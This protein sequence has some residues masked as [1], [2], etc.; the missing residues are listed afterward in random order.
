MD[1]HYLPFMA[2]ILEAE[3]TLTSQNQ[4]TVPIPVRKALNLHGGKSRVR[5]QILPEEGK[6]LFLL[7]EPKSQSNEDLALRPFLNL[8]AQDIENAPKKLTPFPSKLLKKARALTMGVSVDLD[9]PLT[10]ED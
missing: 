6:V 10:G 8:L 2:I 3:A 9:G 7:A 4:I 1:F 5:F